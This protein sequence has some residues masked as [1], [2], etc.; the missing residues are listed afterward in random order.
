MHGEKVFLADSKW[1]QKK[2][3][4]FAAPIFLSAVWE[5]VFH[6]RAL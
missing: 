4:G 2:G 3:L 6:A 5:G 1:G